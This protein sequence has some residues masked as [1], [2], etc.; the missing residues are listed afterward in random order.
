MPNNSIQSKLASIRAELVS[1]AKQVAVAICIATVIAIIG[2]VTGCTNY[3]LDQIEQDVVTSTIEPRLA[4]K[5]ANQDDDVAYLSSEQYRQA[6]HA[7][8]F[9]AKVNGSDHE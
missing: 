2:A 8:A 6:K 5:I 9:L 7:N 3:V 4:A 1:T